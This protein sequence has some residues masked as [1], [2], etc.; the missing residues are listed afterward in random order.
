MNLKHLG[1]PYREC[2]K[3]AFVRSCLVKMSL[4]L[5]LSVSVV[6]TVMPRF[7]RQFRRS[8]QIKKFITNASGVL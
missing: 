2:I 1:W 6:M 3:K 8:L 7:L 5:F 4:R